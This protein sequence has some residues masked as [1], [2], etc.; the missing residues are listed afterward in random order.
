M[1]P[2]RER[3]DLTKSR[4]SV[5]FRFYRFFS[6]ESKK[7][8]QQQLSGPPLLFLTNDGRGFT[9]SQPVFLVIPPSPLPTNQTTPF[10]RH[11]TT[12]KKLQQH[13]SLDKEDFY[14]RDQVGKKMTSLCEHKERIGLQTRKILTTGF[15]SLLFNFTDFLRNYIFATQSFF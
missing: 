12:K 6:W 10:R 3:N 1:T 15:S 13:V 11:N 9:S 7:S 2:K 4:K 8:I 14:V 5:G